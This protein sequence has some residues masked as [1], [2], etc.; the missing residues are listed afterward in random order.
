MDTE[1][2]DIPATSVVIPFAAPADGSPEQL[3]QFYESL[4]GRLRDAHRHGDAE[5]ME[6]LLAGYR[7]SDVPEWAQERMAGYDALARG[8]RFER[9]ARTQGRLEL[10]GDP[11]V[12]ANAGEPLVFELVLMPWSREPALLGG[13]RDEDA[14]GCHVEIAVT[15]HFVDGSARQH[16]DG[17]VLR[18]E[19]AVDLR[20][21]PMRL[22]IRVQLADAGVVRRT[23]ELRA[24]LLPGHVRI[25]DL[26]APV[27]RTPL[28]QMAHT[29]WPRGH[30]AIR[31]QPLATLQNAIRLGDPAH[32]PHV[33]LAAEFAPASE[34]DQ[35]LALLIDQVRLGRPDQ[36]RVAMATLRAIGAAD[37][38]LGD[39]EAWLA[40][41]QRRR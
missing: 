19:R 12:T 24:D 27:R 23:I 35:V 31:E 40:W 8:L 30:R 11:A 14:V 37:L 39:R 16:E 22:P 4:L 34:R 17:A 21:E 2:P 7:R 5:T 1:V 33:R 10:L 36:A 13:G 28:A 29:Q 25:G 3:K 18:L 20:R 41:W 26:R 9:H 15:D 38:P 6:A 32:F